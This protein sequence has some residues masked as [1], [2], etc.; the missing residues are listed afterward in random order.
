MKKLFF[1]LLLLLPTVAQAA[2]EAERTASRE[3]TVPLAVLP[4]EMVN[5]RTVVH[6]PIANY[7]LHMVFDTGASNTALFQSRDFAFDDLEKVGPAK[8]LFPALNEAVEGS[9]LAPIP[10]QFGDHTYTPKKLLLIHKRPPV[11]DRLNFKFDG[12]LGQDF[13]SNYVVEFDPKAHVVRLYTAGTNLRRNYFTRLRLHMK[14]SAPHI[15]FNTQLPWEKRSSFKKLLLDTGF[16]GLMVIWNARHFSMAVGQSN[17]KAYQKENR[18]VFTRATFKLGKLKFM[19]APIFIA[20]NVPQQAQ[21]RDGLIGANILNQF[22]HV[23]DFGNKQLL[24]D[25]GRFQFDRIDGHFYVPNNES[26]IYKN[27]QNFEAASKFVIE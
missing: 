4:T 9:R 23:I 20:S 18:G 26:F 3:K 21:K 1:F 25:A 8:I 10:I 5:N 15:V 17:I 14:Q 12:V 19:R 2:N 22:N 16:P 11:G 7:F 13:F 24:L 27:F 6:L